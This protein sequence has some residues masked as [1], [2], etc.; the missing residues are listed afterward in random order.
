MLNESFEIGKVE[1]FPI[2][3]LTLPK[4]GCYC[5]TYKRYV[6][7][8]DMVYYGNTKKKEKGIIRAL[9]CTLGQSDHETIKLLETITNVDN[10]FYLLEFSYY[11]VE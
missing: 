4:N 2:F 5:G 8:S 1:L 3:D 11:F 6:K 9:Y 10:H 7:V